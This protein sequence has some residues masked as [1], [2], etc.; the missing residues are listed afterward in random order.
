M[1]SKLV[2]FIL[3]I[4]SFSCTTPDKV[5]NDAE[6]NEIKAE[7]KEVVDS[8][9]K[10]VQDSNYD[11]IAEPFLDS[12]D[13]IYV[14]NGYAFSYDEAMEN[15]K[16][17]IEA[18]QNQEFTFLDEKYVFLDDSNV[19]YMMNSKFITNYKDGTS[20]HFDPCI[21]HF[22]FKKIDDTWKVISFVESAVLG[23]P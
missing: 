13:F 23:T 8:Y 20:V 2:I 14:F 15:G 21:L 22:V 11:L 10:G 17:T 9:I 3:L 4:I 12:P 5:L 16:P 18:I 19:I 7:V 6:K 1:K